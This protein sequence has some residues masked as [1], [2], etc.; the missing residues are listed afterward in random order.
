MT[1]PLNETTSYT[2]DNA[3]RTT[4]IQFANDGY[5]TPNKSFT[6]DPVGRVASA[7]GAVYGTETMRYDADGSLLEKDEPTSGS[8]TSPARVTYD[9]YPN[10]Q[11]KDVNIASSALNASPFLAY[12]YRVD[13]SR[14]TLHVGFGQQQGNFSSSYTDAGRI[15]S[16]S[17]PF[18]GSTMPSPQSPVAAGTTYP[19]TTWAY[20]AAGQLT[21]LSLPQTLAYQSITHER[22]GLR[23]HLDGQQFRLR[24]RPNDVHQHDPWRERHAVARRS[25]FGCLPVENR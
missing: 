14:S 7:T 5:V 15:I 6:Y 3:G 13:G 12:S 22:R 21:T 24:P 1:D 2:Y 10:G 8:I 20:D 11:R 9:Y 17:D 19:P 23:R 4:T 16:R 18:T 25:E